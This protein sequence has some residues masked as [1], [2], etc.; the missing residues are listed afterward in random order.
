MSIQNL[1]LSS[2]RVNYRKEVLQFLRGVM[3]PSLMVEIREVVGGTS[4]QLRTALHVLMSENKVIQTGTT[5]NTRYSLVISASAT[6]DHVPSV[7]SAPAIGN[8]AIAKVVTEAVRFI[9]N[10]PKIRAHN[11][12]QWRVDPIGCAKMI[13]AVRDTPDPRATLQT[14]ADRTGCRR[15]SL[16]CLLNGRSTDNE[17]WPAF[18]AELERL[19]PTAPATTTTTTAVVETEPATK[20]VSTYELDPRTGD[21]LIVMRTRVSYGTPDHVR[22]MAHLAHHSK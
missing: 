18:Q 3:R 8:K 4:H 20:G 7:P 9:T 10:L 2:V 16:T 17:V 22:C 21:I 13:A 15:Q 14:I 12:R 11:G 5:R 1:H 6:T 19:T